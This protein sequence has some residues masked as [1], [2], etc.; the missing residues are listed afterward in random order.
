MRILITVPWGQ[1]LG[2]AEVML[3]ALLEG[4][5]GT[6]HELELVFFQGGPWPDE[7]AAGGLRVEVIRAGRMRQA[8]LAAATVVKLA[9]V[10]HRRQPDLILSWSPKAHL[11]CS[12]AAVL[13]GM[14]DRVTWWQHSIPAPAALMDRAATVLPAV[15]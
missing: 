3:Q 11:Y 9:R 15:A 6:E 1:R 4:G 5:R 10:L 8:H 14:A 7:L 2:G 13:A 12:P